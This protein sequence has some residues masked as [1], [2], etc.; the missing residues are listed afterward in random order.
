MLAP[1]KQVGAGRITNIRAG[2]SVVEQPFYVGVSGVGVDDI[3]RLPREF[4]E[5]E[6]E[7]LVVHEVGTDE[8]SGVA[9]TDAIPLSHADRRRRPARKLGRPADG[10]AI[11]GAQEKTALL[12]CAVGH[13]ARAV[14]VAPAGEHRVGEAGDDFLE[15]VRVGDNRCR[16]R[17]DEKVIDARAPVSVTLPVGMRKYSPKPSMFPPG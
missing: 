9:V 5:R 1:R 17:R 7:A 16:C 4:A 3:A 11:H 15:A 8:I 12:A 10:G 2:P 6:K 13:V 14:S